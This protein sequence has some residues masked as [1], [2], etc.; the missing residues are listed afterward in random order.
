[1]TPLEATKIGYTSLHP[2]LSHSGYAIFI[3]ENAL[4]FLN[5]AIQ[6]NYAS[7]KLIKKL[8]SMR[9]NPRPWD[10]GIKKGTTDQRQLSIENIWVNYFIS[11]GCVYIDSIKPNNKPKASQE[12]AGMTEVTDIFVKPSLN[13][14]IRLAVSPFALIP[15]LLPL[16]F[17]SPAF[18]T[19]ANPYKN[20]GNYGEKV[21]SNT[22]KSIKQL[23]NR[24]I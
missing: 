18:S 7:F 3:H 13:S 19:H 10:G 5:E 14:M 1:M 17:S 20:M 21:V 6:D 24:L 15:G 11:N 16:A 8:V 23:I 22:A 12:L 4:N 9:S 2:G